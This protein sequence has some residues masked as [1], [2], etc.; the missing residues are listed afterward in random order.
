M[1]L[2][3]CLFA[4][5]GSL[6][7]V[8]A[9]PAAPLSALQNDV[10]ARSTLSEV[11]DARS[12]TDDDPI[13]ARYFSETYEITEREWE[14]A[15]L[16]PRLYAQAAK[17]VV[18]VIEVVVNAIKGQIEKDKT[19]RGHWTSKM[20]GDLRAKSPRFNFVLCHTKHKTSFKGKQ[21][22]DWGHSHQELHVSFGK[23][24][25]YEIYWFKEGTFERIGDG[26]WLNWAYSGAVKNKSGDGKKLTFGAP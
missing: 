13:F 12:I 24:V 10:Q 22:V 8:S 6:A 26:G 25:G 16:E 3:A 18:K 4:F 23:T 15:A 14:E 19:M 11:V 7:V 21:G 1:K 17:V 20:I 5:F 9:L 2:T